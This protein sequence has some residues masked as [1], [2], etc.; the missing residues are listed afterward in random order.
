M[1][2][3]I[4]LVIYIYIYIHIYIYIYIYIYYIY[5][6]I[7]I[8]IHVLISLGQFQPCLKQSHYNY[9][10]FKFFLC[11]EILNLIESQYVSYH[12]NVLVNAFHISVCFIDYCLTSYL[13][14]LF[15][16]N[17]IIN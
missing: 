9:Q 8:Y 4:I 5:I 13:T 6:Y 16:L 17:I 12:Y 10:L 1:L 11:V 14:K 3:Y 2:L 15:V 7:Y